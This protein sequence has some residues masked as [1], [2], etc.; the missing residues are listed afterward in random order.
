MVDKKFEEYQLYVPDVHFELIPIKNL[1][2]NQDYQRNLSINHVKKT[3]ADFSLYQL[4]PVKVSRRNGINYVFNGQHTIEVVALISGTRETP[5]WCMIYD[6]LIYEEEADIFANQTKFVKP[7]SPYETF[8]ANVEAESDMHLII[9][10]LVESYDMVISPSNQPGCICAVGSLEYIYDRYGFQVLDKTLRLIIGTWEGVPTSF[11][12]NML[13]GVAH[14]VF[15]FG[16]AINEE[17][18]KE[19]CSRESVKTI[20]RDA[21][22]R[23]GG[24]LGYSEILIML[25]NKGS[26]GGL[27]QDKLHSD[28][29]KACKEYKEKNKG[30]GAKTI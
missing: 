27:S 2:S 8:N 15:S 25:Y 3:A 10:D 23:K 7:L 22:A 1:V 18:F 16:D 17:V 6:D 28:V 13:K 30:N 4:N 14:M 21:K 12:G 11:S 26:R 24:A 20:S 29:R 9:K 19:K 5:V